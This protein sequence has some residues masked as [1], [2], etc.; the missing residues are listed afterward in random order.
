M[1]RHI[2][3][4]VLDCGKGFLSESSARG[5]SSRCLTQ[6]C[7]GVA[8]PCRRSRFLWRS[9][10]GARPR[11]CPVWAPASR[12]SGWTRSRFSQWCINLRLCSGSEP[13]PA[14]PA[15]CRDTRK[16]SSPLP[17]APPASEW[18]CSSSSACCPSLCLL[19]DVCV[20]RVV[21]VVLETWCKGGVFCF[22]YLASGSG[23]TTVRFWDL[24]TETP[25]HT[26]R[27]RKSYNSGRIAAPEFDADD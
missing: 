16:P 9:S 15:P 27:G 3:V 7:S 13:W 14:A 1:H 12:P 6:M 21:A 18:L 20:S 17:L 26:A 19:V 24:T 25:H 10:C 8:A 22:R 23:D 4:S 2:S 5:L 11:W